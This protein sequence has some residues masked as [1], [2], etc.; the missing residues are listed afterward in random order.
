MSFS[1]FIA[2]FGALVVVMMLGVYYGQPNW[3]FRLFHPLR[4]P[5][6]IKAHATNYH[7]P[8]D[9]I[10][11]VVFQESRFDDRARSAAGA[12]GLMQL[13]PD[14]AHG[15]AALTGGKQ[16]TTSDLTDPE[17]NIRYGTFYLARLHRKYLKHGSGWTLALAAYNAGQGKVD[18]WIAA[19]K[20]GN[21]TEAEIPFAETRTYVHN[22]LSL[23]GHYHTAYA[24]Q[25]G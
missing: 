8:P 17:V 14:T 16:F 2:L 15:I 19:D 24:G 5:T 22:V 23:R 12:V 1:R 4:Y 13:T 7:V 9:L 18:S 3:Y 10:A 6:Y 21:L 20:D 25:L 11:A